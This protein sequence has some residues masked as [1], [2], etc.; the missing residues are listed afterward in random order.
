MR[1]LQSAV[2]SLAALQ[3]PPWTESRRPDRKKCN[4]LR[5]ARL[6]A[7]IP[8][9]GRIHQ[10]GNPTG[11]RG[12]AS[13]LPLR[14]AR[15]FLQDGL[16][17]LSRRARH[18]AG[19]SLQRGRMSSAFRQSRSGSAPPKRSHQGPSLEFESNQFRQRP[20]A[21][22]NSGA[23]ADSLEVHRL[24]YWSRELSRLEAHAGRLHNKESAYVCLTTESVRPRSKFLASK[25]SRAPKPVTAPRMEG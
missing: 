5:P 24:G 15:I 14:A 22:W 20:H 18:P 8:G 4:P 2:R 25:T 11:L 12:S 3:T 13:W 9:N 21:L 1:R 7:P 6:R 23:N 10:S 19:H 17:R 16:P